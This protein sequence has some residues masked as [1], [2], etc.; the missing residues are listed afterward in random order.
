MGDALEALEIDLSELGGPVLAPGYGAQGADA[1]AVAAVFSQVRTMV[2][3][4][5]S[6]G[7]L[8]SGPGV[9]SLRD[10]MNRSAEEL[11]ARLSTP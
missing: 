1:D 8:A 5:S 6:R 10:A 9:A 3:A 11:A 2:L 7:V 4:N